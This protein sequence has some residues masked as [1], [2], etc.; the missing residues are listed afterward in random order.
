MPVQELGLTGVDFGDN[1]LIIDL[2]QQLTKILFAVSAPYSAKCQLAKFNSVGKAEWDLTEIE[3]QPGQGGYDSPICGIRIASFDPANPT[4]VLLQGYYEDDPVPSGFISSTAEFSGGTLTPGAGMINGITGKV[5]A[6]GT[7]LLGT[8]F[9]SIRTGLGNYT[10][11]F[12]PALASNPIILLSIGQATPYIIIGDGSASAAGFSPS[13][14][15][16]AT[17]LNVDSIW[18]F[19]AFIPQ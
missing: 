4:S 2:S 5:D 11:T 7:K 19:V 3:L 9:T 12:A 18:D 17:G 10:I 16:I 13:I 6:D 8:G 1:G 14:V 15:S